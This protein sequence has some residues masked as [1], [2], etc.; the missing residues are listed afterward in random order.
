MNR[1]ATRL[2]TAASRRQHGISLIIVLVALALMSLAAVGL[3]RNVD[4]GTLVVGNLAF[5]QG[6]TAIADRASESAI[7][8][9]ETNNSGAT[10][11]ENNANSGYYAT[12]LTNL[13]VAGKSSNAARS[14]VDWKGDGCAW[15]TGGSYAA[16]VSPAPAVTANGHTTRYLVTRMCKTTG[17]PND[18]ANSC[19]KP[20]VTS[21]SLS[22]KRGELKYA[23]DKRFAQL[24]GP[25]FRIVVRSEGPRN[26][27]SFTE[28]YIHF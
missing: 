9:L 20:L 22:G 13:D 11:F 18:T 8:W 24:V 27:V 19:A 25:Y 1:H 7:A 14:V 16:C 4:T 12:S 17:D 2:P 15:A 6:A 21:A 10:L 23:E 5:K 3:I 28:T 26:T